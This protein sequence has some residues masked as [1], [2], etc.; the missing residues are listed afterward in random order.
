MEVNEQKISFQERLK[1]LKTKCISLFVKKKNVSSKTELNTKSLKIIGLCFVLIFITVA[2]LMPNEQPIEFVEKIQSAP[3][4]SPAQKDAKNEVSE[5]SASNLWASP[6]P[7]S[8]GGNGGGGGSQINYNTSTILG[9]KNGNART[10]L[11]AGLRLP[12]RIIDKFIVS[13]DA[14]PIMAELILNSTTESGLTLPAGT[15]FYGEASFQKGAERASVQFKQISLPNG[16]I[17]PIA[18]L[19]VGKDGQP[20]LPGK[21]YSDGMKNTTGQVLTTF[22][23]GLA[24]GSVQT[25]VF[26]QSRGGLE[27]GMLA[28]VAATAKDRAQAYGEKLKAER[29]WIEV[30]AGA[31]GDALL[32]DSLN[33]QIESNQ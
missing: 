29:E 1:N 19:A 33:L 7:S 11:R 24:A 13:Q 21:V 27:N 32:N 5:G 22:I 16:E 2:L 25:D 12:I 17:R 30:G 9:S 10:Q 28:A 18:G 20:G 4:S 23:G 8:Y 31:E 6:R 3:Q 15:R 26:G 14:V